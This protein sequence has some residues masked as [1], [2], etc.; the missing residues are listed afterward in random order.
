MQKYRQLKETLRSKFAQK[1][2]TK[3]TP[4]RYRKNKKRNPGRIFKKNCPVQHK[5]E[6]NFERKNTKLSVSLIKN[7]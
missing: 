6:L 2:Q 7:R 4:A 1:K 5:F 3:L